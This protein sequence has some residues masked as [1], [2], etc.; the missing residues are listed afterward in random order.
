MYH[1]IIDSFLLVDR[2]GETSVKYF[3][4]QLFTVPSVAAHVVQY[5][6][7]LPR[8]LAIITAFFTEQI[9]GSRIEFPP[10]PTLPVDPESKAFKSKRFMPVFADLRYL[11]ANHTV[12]SIICQNSSHITGFSKVCQMF[13]GIHPNQRLSVNHV[14]Y[15]SETWI[16]V[17]NVTLSLSRVVKAYG[18][19]YCKATPAQLIEAIG[20]VSQHILAVCTLQEARLDTTKYNPILSHVVEFCSEKYQVIEFNCL[21]GAISFH[22]ALHWLLAELFKHVGL[23]SRE[24]L[25][26]VNSQSLR[27]VMLMVGP[28]LDFLTLI[29]FPLRG[30]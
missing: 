12:Q 13:M 22:H 7:I 9:K 10:N 1:R 5:H 6:N 4:L 3:A 2:E 30:K 25:Q 14:E 11:V 19:A 16:N 28:E 27:D 23:L 24:A 15:E 8:L 20:I 17:F 29:D 21:T 26:S 18:E